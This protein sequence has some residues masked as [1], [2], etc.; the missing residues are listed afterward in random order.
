MVG[1]VVAICA[2]G[3]LRTI[4][5]AWYARASRAPSTRLVTRNAISLTFPLPMAYAERIRR[6]DGVSSVSWSNWFGGVY[7]TERNFFPQFAV[8][9]ASYPP[10]YPGVRAEGRRRKTFM[11]DQQ[12]A[13][14]GASSPTVRLEGGD[15][16]PIPAIYPGNW[17]SRCAA[18]RTAP[19]PRPTRTQIFHWAAFRATRRLGAAPTG[20][21][22]S[23]GIRDPNDAAA[24]RNAAIDASSPTRAET[25]DR[26]R[27]GVPARLRLDEQ[28]GDPGRLSVGDRR[29]SSSSSWR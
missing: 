24:D 3:L 25:L 8:D 20:A 14:P 23:S 27:A 2:F 1:L 18:S 12:G 5:D 15:R 16:I 7:V 19:T 9:P 13:S 26:N 21:S 11:L 17:A 28:E 10:L 6:I 29:S 4:V 22:S